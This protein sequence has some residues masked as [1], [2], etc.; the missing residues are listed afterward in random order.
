MSA[1]YYLEKAADNGIYP[2]YRELVRQAAQGELIHNEDIPAKILELMKDINEKP[3][4]TGMFTTGRE[5]FCAPH[6]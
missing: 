1:L 2:A 4:R 6:V 3:A 5:G